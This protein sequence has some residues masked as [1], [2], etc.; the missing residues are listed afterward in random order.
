[1]IIDKL[2]RTFF[3]IYLART[4]KNQDVVLLLTAEEAPRG[5]VASDR[6]VVHVQGRVDLNKTWDVI[7]LQLH[8]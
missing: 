4:G 1:M 8:Y 5:A 7:T 3:T 2:T 6:E